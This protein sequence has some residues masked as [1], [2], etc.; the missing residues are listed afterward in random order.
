M[1]TFAR[2]LPLPSKI[3]NGM[4]WP[5][6]TYAAITALPITFMVFA[7][8]AFSRFWSEMPSSF[9]LVGNANELPEEVRS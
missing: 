2:G 5:T 9:S 4:S 3:L 7:I 6:Y 1:F 8:G